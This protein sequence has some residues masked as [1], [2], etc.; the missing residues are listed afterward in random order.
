M[1]AAHPL[2]LPG[3][4]LDVAPLDLADFTPE[5]QAEIQLSLASLAAG[6]SRLSPHDEV[7]GALEAKRLQQGG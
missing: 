6:R 2:P 3:D 5:E 1:T 4:E 7:R